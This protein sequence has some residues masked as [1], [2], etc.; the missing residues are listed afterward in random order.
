MTSTR[1]FSGPK[2]PDCWWPRLG[3]FIERRNRRIIPGRQC[4]KSLR[5]GLTVGE[6]DFGFQE[7]SALIQQSS[8]LGFTGPSGF[9]VRWAAFLLSRYVPPGHEAFE[10]HSS[11][12]AIVFRSRATPVPPTHRRQTS[13]PDRHTDQA[14]PKTHE[15]SWGSLSVAR[16]AYPAGRF[17]PS[18]SW[19]YRCVE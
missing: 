12:I 14:V 18:D 5:F 15:R 9:I 1:V 4:S 3:I 8:A 2:L 10:W 6:N 19:F 17:E 11:M 7:S 13:A 16:R